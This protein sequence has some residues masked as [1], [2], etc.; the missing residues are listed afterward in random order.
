MVTGFESLDCS[1]VPAQNRGIM[2]CIDVGQSPRIGV[3]FGE[4]GG[5]ETQTALTVRAD[6]MIYA[7]HEIGQRVSSPTV[8]N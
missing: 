6:V 8:R 1:G 2:S 7:L 5:G 3:I 4:K